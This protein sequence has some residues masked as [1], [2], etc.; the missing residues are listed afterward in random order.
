MTGVRLDAV[1]KIYPGRRGRPPVAAMDGLDLDIAPGELLVLL[2]PSGCGKSTTLRSLAGLETPDSGRIVQGDRV[3]FDSAQ[4]LDVPPERRNIG[5]VF[6]SYALWPHKTV[7]ANIGYPL[8]ARKLRKPGWV[9]EAAALVDCS[10]LLDR[11]PAQLS[12]GQQ[13]RVGLARGIVARP[14]L[15]LL[16]EPLSNLDARLRDQVRTQLHELHRRLGFTG[17]YVTHDQVEALALGDRVAVM[18]AG[19]IEQLGT[20]EDV[21]S[22]PATEYVADFVGFTERLDVTRT[23]GGWEAAGRPL[24]GLTTVCSGEPDKGATLRFRNDDV[25]VLP[26]GTDPDGLVGLGYATVLD[27]S[28]LGRS[29]ELTLDVVDGGVL[30]AHLAPGD[31]LASA[32]AGD[33]VTV[34]IA[35]DRVLAF[36][37]GRT[38]AS[39][40]S[41]AAS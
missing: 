10:E 37:R 7:R 26:R 13:Q 39:S 34:A 35:A 6:Q 14:D 32:A 11:Y 20:P 33:L 9:E 8:T 4:R 3:V 21:F 2:G 38:S 15:V 41:R 19:R 24:V 28:F 25:R 5:M 29:V 27:R 23:T 18:R 1:S 16:D 12:G 36:G 30:R 31:G 17:V 22:S 40:T